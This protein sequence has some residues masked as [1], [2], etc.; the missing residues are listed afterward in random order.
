MSNTWEPKAGEWVAVKGPT[1][2]RH[3]KVTRRTRTQARIGD[4]VY[5][6]E[7]W[8]GRV[9]WRRRMYL[10]SHYLL[11]PTR[12][13]AELEAEHMAK[14][15]EQERYRMRRECEAAVLTAYERGDDDAIR[16]AIHELEKG[17]KP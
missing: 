8:G 2:I 14:V 6:R 4:D 12:P 15:R 7:E 1:R 16:R 17:T 3:E 13:Q 5:R 10:D 9:D 11:P